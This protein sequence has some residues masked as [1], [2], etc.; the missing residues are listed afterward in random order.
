MAIDDAHSIFLRTV[1]W[2]MIGPRSAALDAR[3]CVVPGLDGLV[4]GDV[5][6]L[7]PMRGV[8]GHKTLVAKALA[9]IVLTYRATPARLIRSRVRMVLGVADATP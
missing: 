2:L 8:A 6:T 3:P 9:W 5:G 4:T 1:P 7:G